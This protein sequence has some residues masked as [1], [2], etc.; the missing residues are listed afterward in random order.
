[1]DPA[2]RSA[3]HALSQEEMCFYISRVDQTPYPQ[4]FFNEILAQSFEVL[5]TLWYKSYM[6]LGK[7]GPLAVQSGTK[8]TYIRSARSG[9]MPSKR[10]Q[11]LM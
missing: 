1:M 9:E 7:R 4:G 10:W 11:T 6:Y 5:R 8:A 3:L 2:A